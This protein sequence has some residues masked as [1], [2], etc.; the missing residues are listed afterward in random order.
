M[1][2]LSKDAQKEL[3][4][5][6]DNK[7]EAMFVPN[8]KLFSLEVHNTNSTDESLSNLE[9]EIESYPELKDSLQHFLDNPDMKR[10]T[11]KE[12]KD[13]RVDPRE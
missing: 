4:N 2:A 1:L 9:E 13:R 3:A 7:D 11:A 8:G 10:Y 12:L 6:L 5:A